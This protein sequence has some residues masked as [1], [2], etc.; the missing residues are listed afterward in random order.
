MIEIPARV[1]RTEAGT[2]W[3]VAAAP[4]SCGACGG[5]GCGSSLFARIFHGRESEYPVDNP[6][7]A[8]AGETVVVGVPD[9]ALFRA[10][11]AAY[12]VPLLLMVLGA[13]IAAPLGDA[14]AVFGAL[15]GLAGAFFWMRR[16][17]DAARPAILRQGESH[18]SSR[19]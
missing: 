17:N 3:V 8:R 11:L 5:K 4:T 2:A 1:V 7:A 10:T 9:G 15:T 13:V 18:C 6:I 14:Y 19:N 16:Q 12:L